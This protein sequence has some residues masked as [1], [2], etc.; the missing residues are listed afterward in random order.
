MSEVRNV[1]TCQV[2]NACK[3]KTTLDDVA[4]IRQH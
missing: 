1:R 2:S 4:N 3:V